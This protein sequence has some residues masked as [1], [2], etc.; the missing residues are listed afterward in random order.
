MTGLTVTTKRRRRR[1][2][3]KKRAGNGTVV[4]LHNVAVTEPIQLTIDANGV[5]AFTPFALKLEQTAMRGKGMDW[6]ADQIKAYD[7]FRFTRLQVEWVPSLSAFANG[8]AGMYFDPDPAATAPASFQRMSGNESLKTFKVSSKMRL[9]IPMARMNR[10]P[11]YKSTA[12]DTDACVGSIIMGIS[13]G[14]LANTK[15]TVSAGFLRIIYDLELKNPTSGGAGA[16]LSDTS[17]PVAI[18]M[19]RA[20][21][22][23]RDLAGSRSDFQYGNTIASWLQGISLPIASG[24]IYVQAKTTPAGREI[25]ETQTDALQE[26]VDQ[27]EETPA[28]TSSEQSH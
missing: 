9:D 15:G 17:H 4:R 18:D 13:S 2:R 16:V 28:G 19:A 26:G 6:A 10:L 1:G 8:T 11:W 23:L 22:H 5:W 12:S 21:D 14:S 27:R 24:N 20:L 25:A 3:G 7:L